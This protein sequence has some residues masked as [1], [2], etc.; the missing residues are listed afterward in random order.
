M[1]VKLGTTQSNILKL[2]ITRPSVSIF[3][4]SSHV[5]HGATQTEN[6]KMTH[7]GRFDEI[8]APIS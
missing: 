2:G 5:K 8:A 3:E 7:S 1:Q 4:L 6:L